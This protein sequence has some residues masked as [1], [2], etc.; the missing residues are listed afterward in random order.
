MFPKNGTTTATTLTIKVAFMKKMPL[1]LGVALAALTFASCKKELEQADSSPAI[2]AASTLAKP[3]LLT[4]GTWQQ[5]GLTVSTAGE[6][7]TQA[8]TSDIFTHV[9]PSMLIKSASYKDGGTF[10]QVRGA[11]AGVVAA[12]PQAGTWRL[13]EAAD[14]LIVTQANTTL[15]LAVTELTGSTMRLTYTQNDGGKAS[16]YTSV[17][18]H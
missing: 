14:S 4:T 15:R 16:T 18:S 1:F 13:T 6:G 12:E 3:A 2:A 11:R 9:K 17:F 10:L 5:T 8:I 7:T